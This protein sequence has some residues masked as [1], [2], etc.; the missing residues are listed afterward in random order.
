MILKE[1]TIGG[2]VYLEEF[3]DEMALPENERVAFHYGPLTTRERVDLL[4]STINGSGRPNGADVCLKSID[5][6]GKKI[7]N[8]FGKDGSPV[9]TVSKC[10]LYSTDNSLAYIIEIVGMHIWDRQNISEALIKNSVSPSIA[11]EKATSSPTL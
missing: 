10:I 3:D 9:D 7:S 1:A 5:G 4:H 2:V 6:K 8:L 11:D